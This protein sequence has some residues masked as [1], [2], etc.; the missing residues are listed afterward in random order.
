MIY[1]YLHPIIADRWVGSAPPGR[2]MCPWPNPSG[3]IWC[4]ETKIFHLGANYHQHL[5]NVTPRQFEKVIASLLKEVL[6]DTGVELTKKSRDGGIDLIC[7]DGE[8]S[9]TSSNPSNALI[10]Q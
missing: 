8:D 7:I 5:E 10:K 4:G 3:C 2:G 9:K 1:R 6:P